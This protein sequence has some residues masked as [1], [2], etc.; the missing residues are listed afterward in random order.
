MNILSGLFNNEVIKKAAFSGLRK[1]MDEQKLTCIVLRNNPEKQDGPLPGFDVDMFTEPVA[2]FPNDTI[3]ISPEQFLQY[4][5]M[6]RSYAEITEILPGISIDQLSAW[7]DPEVKNI[8]NRYLKAKKL[9]DGSDNTES[10]PD[11]DN[12]DTA[13]K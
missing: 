13:T 11:S 9:T 7:N 12:G 1:I 4:N 6:I 3:G 8:I 2:I 10:A 5:T